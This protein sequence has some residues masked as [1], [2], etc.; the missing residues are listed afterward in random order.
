MNRYLL[1]VVALYLVVG[2][3]AIVA[4]DWVRQ[5]VVGMN[6][7]PLALQARRQGVVT[8]DCSIGQ[9]GLVKSVRT[10][11]NSEQRSGNL[12]SHA[13]EDN[14]M[15]WKFQRLKAGSV[16]NTSSIVVLQYAFILEGD[17][18]DCPRGRFV[19]EYPGSVTVTSEPMSPQP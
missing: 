14:A 15:Q 2:C 5:K 13:A 19:F 10:V 17:S 1:S 16:S 7:P 9:D 12:L 8:L 6:Y 11:S 18:R 4:Q 3:E